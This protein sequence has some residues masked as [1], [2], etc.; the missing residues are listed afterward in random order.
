[1]LEDN[2]SALPWF[3]V[4]QTPFVTCARVIGGDQDLSGMHRE[5]LPQQ[6]FDAAWLDL[7]PGEDSEPVK[8]NSW[9][10]SPQFPCTRSGVGTANKIR[11][12]NEIQ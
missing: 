8:E 11:V 9:M 7:V 1:L 2:V 10:Q 4:D 6:N 3:I 12:V 5:G